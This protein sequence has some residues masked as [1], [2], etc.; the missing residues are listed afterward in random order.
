MGNTEEIN[1]NKLVQKLQEENKKL[2]KKVRKANIPGR[3]VESMFRL[4]A[5]N[6]INLSSIAD[7]KANILIS[8]NS[9]I[10]TVLLTYGVGKIADYRQEYRRI[11]QFIQ[12]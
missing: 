5:R 12:K 10:L 3:G 1:L 8:V 7:N 4:T 9:I 6:Q 11:G 2:K